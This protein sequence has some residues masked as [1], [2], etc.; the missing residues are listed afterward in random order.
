MT[1]S[2]GFLELACCAR[3]YSREVGLVEQ[4]S[5]NP[6]SDFTLDEL[7]TMVAEGW[8]IEET[9]EA[10]KEEFGQVSYFA[11]LNLL[12]NRFGLSFR[13]KHMLLLAVLPELDLDFQEAF[14][15]LGEPDGRPS[16]KLE[17]KIFFS[18][19]LGEEDEKQN[20]LRYSLMQELF[21]KDT[22]QH[23]RMS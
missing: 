16:F 3:A 11:R 10:A 8:R 19:A 20:I 18:A 1:E 14:R 5:W 9:D 4:Q 22:N 2:L 6:L 13:E 12:Q 23:G 15:Y 7:R 17:N 21:L